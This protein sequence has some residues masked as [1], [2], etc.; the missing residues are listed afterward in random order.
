MGNTLGWKH[1]GA[2]YIFI[3]ITFALP[4]CSNAAVSSIVLDVPNAGFF[5]VAFR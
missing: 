4:W 3:F 5:L 1:E 2:R